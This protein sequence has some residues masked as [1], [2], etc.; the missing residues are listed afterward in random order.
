MNVLLAT[1]ANRAR[2]VGNELLG[3][4]IL[5]GTHTGEVDGAARRLE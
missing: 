4:P 3:W 2:A 5:G 1:P